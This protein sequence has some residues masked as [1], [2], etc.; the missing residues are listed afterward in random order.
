MS[1][2]N[3]SSGIGSTAEFLTSAL[4]YVTSSTAPSAGSPVRITLPKVS[5]FITLLNRDTTPGNSVSI[6][7]TRAGVVSTN[8]KFVVPGGQQVTLDLRVKE[9]WIQ[10][11]AGTP[12][13]SLCVGL[14]TI[15]SRMMPLLSGTM[16]NNTPGW[17]GVG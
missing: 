3:P 7:F 8:N 4:P 13:Y 6:G 11:E 14:T 10:A 16:P 9:L 17:D 2:D 15:D 1:L 12:A 5:K